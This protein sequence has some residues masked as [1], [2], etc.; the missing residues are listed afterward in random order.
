MQD[1][2]LA[3]CDRVREERSAK[4]YSARQSRVGDVDRCD[5]RCWL[6][7]TTV[8]HLRWPVSSICL[9]RGS[10]DPTRLGDHSQR[11]WLDK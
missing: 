11:K 3:C 4:G 2:D 9:V 7:S 1:Y 6:I 5:Q 10:R 8:P